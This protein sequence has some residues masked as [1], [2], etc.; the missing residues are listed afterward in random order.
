M[1]PYEFDSTLV[2]FIYSEA[3]AHGV[4]G[5]NG[6]LLA[7]PGNKNAVVDNE[8]AWYEVVSTKTASMV[9]ICEGCLLLP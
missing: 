9:G 4:E 2:V 1:G 3:T 5:S 6:L 8:V 7:S